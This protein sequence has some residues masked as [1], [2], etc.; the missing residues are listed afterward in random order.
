MG[1]KCLKSKNEA[2][3]IEDHEEIRQ[4]R[5]SR[6]TLESSEY[7]DMIN[8]MPTIPTVAME[9]QGNNPL[10]TQTSENINDSI[11]WQPRAKRGELEEQ[12]E[13]DRR[14]SSKEEVPMRLKKNH[15]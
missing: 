12:F 11:T 4:S 6:K 10:A 5:K 3:V 1:N 7:K 13:F 9:T 8:R 14:M 15:D 2:E